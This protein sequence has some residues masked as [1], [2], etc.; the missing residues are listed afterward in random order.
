MGAVMYPNQPQ[1][2]PAPQPPQQAP[3]QA[4]APSPMSA[5]YLNQIAPQSPK[6]PLLKMGP[7]LIAIIAG[8]LV[9]LVIILSVVVNT[10]ASGQ[11]EPVERLSARLTTTQA[12]VSAAQPNLKSSQLRSLNSNLKIYLTNT[13]RD[14]AEPLVSAKI[15]VKKLDKK[16]VAAESG[17]KLLEILED[18]RLNVDYD[19]VYAREMSYKLETTMILMEQIYSSTSSKKLKTFLE[20]AYKNLEPTQKAFADFNAA[21]G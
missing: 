5:D 4:P 12:V 21:N 13:N 15:D 8:I 10:I 3:V 16:I 14:I 7:K 18:A 20:S 11:R 9:L 6:V 19:R 1:V 2:P 17:D